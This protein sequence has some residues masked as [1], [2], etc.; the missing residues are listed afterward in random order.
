MV[1]KFFRGAKVFEPQKVLFF[2]KFCEI[3]QQRRNENF[4]LSKLRNFRVS[5]EKCFFFQNSDWSTSKF[6]RCLHFC[7]QND[8]VLV[9]GFQTQVVQVKRVNKCG[10]CG[11]FWSSNGWSTC[12][13]YYI[14][15]LEQIDY[16]SPQA[17]RHPAKQRRF[18]LLG[19]HSH[20][21]L[22]RAKL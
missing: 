10:L 4:F 14:N 1:Q 9:P 20:Q 21:K 12:D 19:F 8:S 17:S 22:L 18:R 16:F 3:L 15:G 6:C 11:L 13:I 5:V 7:N 2:E